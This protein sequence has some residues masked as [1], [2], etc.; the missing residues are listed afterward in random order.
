[1]L[2]RHANRA[3]HLL[4]LFSLLILLAP[5]CKQKEAETA[6]FPPASSPSVEAGTPANLQNPSTVSDSTGVPH[7]ADLGP[8]T[9][10]KFVE[11]PAEEDPE[12]A[13]PPEV[14]LELAV[15]VEDGPGLE[16]QVAQAPDPKPAAP[17]KWVDDGHDY[18]Q[19]DFNDLQVDGE[20]PSQLSLAVD[21]NF[22]WQIQM[23]TT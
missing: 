3:A 23:M 5:G 8:E 13:L 4:G 20:L 15:P 9:L 16:V 1:M 12:P 2:Q 17:R 6:V 22:H 7:F 11:V 21:N 18:Y 10:V 19:V 14:N